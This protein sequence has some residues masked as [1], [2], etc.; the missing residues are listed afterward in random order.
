ME[1]IGFIGLGAM[2]RPMASNLRRKGFELLVYDVQ[3]EPCAGLAALGA[4]VARS[5]GEVAREAS[6]VVTMLPDSPDVEAVALGAG[7]IAE[8]AH[9]GL[10]VMDMSTVDPATTDLLAERLLARGIAFVDAPV[11]RLV[12]HAERGESLFM[13]GASHNDFGRV[14]PLLEAMGTT[15]HHCGKPGTGIR[16]KLVNNYLAIISCQ[17]NAE[18]LAL[19]Q[20]YG[21]DLAKTLEVV[22]GTTATNGQ[23]KQGWPFKVLKGDIAPGFRIALAHKDLSL[24]VEA[25]RKAGV[26]VYVG[27]VAREC[28]GQAKRT[29]DYG[30]KDF[31]ALLEIVCRQAGIKPPR[32]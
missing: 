32:L 7:G 13:V 17:V 18:A 31:S 25:A 5:V 30:E 20:A 3:P 11:G 19:A 14:K 23:L 27:A 29:G 21:L 2:G 26:P 12:S 22:N 8:H 1:R 16:T 10:L 9:E 4:K 24:A 28:L 15:V 6:L